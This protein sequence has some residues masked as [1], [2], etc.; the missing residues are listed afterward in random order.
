MNTDQ[1]LKK[2]DRL[3]MRDGLRYEDETDIR[4]WVERATAGGAD[5][6]TTV[7]QEKSLER[8]RALFHAHF[9]RA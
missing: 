3:T 9:E 1:M 5:F 7:L 6:D 4:T 2:L 8:I